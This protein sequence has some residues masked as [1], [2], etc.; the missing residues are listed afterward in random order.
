MKKVIKRLT[1][2]STWAASSDLTPVDLPREGLITEVT[3]RANITA[4]LTAAAYDDWFRRVI[5]SIKIQGDGG[6]TYLGMGGEQ[7]STILSLWNEVVMGMPTLHSNGAGIALASPDVGSTAFVSVFKFHPGSNPKDPFDLSACIPAKKLSTLQAIL[8]TTAAAVTDAAG[9][10]SA[11]T[12]NYEIAEVLPEPGDIGTRI[13]K[14][15]MAPM[16]STLTYTHTATYS[17]FGYTIDVPTG[18]FLRSILMRVMDDTATVPRR[19]DDEITAL[20]LYL[21]RTGEIVFEQNIYELKQTM[22]ARF[23]CR[24][25]A[26]DVG[27]IGAIATIRPAPGAGLDIVPAGFAVIDLRPFGNPLYGL[28]LRGY[29]TGDLKLG[30]TIGSYSAGDDSTWYFDQLVPEDAE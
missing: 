28:D 13:P 2:S 10:I 16:G 23:G 14:R 11:G 9:A 15:I 24:G 3:I 27:P 1:A 20:K 21:P 12:F 5:Q 22:M 19:K 25:I 18:A 30:L 6:R 17:D 7:M 4:T 8:A 29:Q 26:G